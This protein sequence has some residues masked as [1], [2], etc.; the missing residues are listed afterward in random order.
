MLCELISLNYGGHVFEFSGILPTL[1]LF[2]GKCHRV[3]KLGH[4]L[5]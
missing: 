3:V 1:I 2:L 5:G 4:V